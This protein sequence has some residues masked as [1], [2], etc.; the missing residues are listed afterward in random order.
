MKAFQTVL[1]HIEPEELTALARDLVRIPSV[2]R[3]QHGGN[4]EGVAL[5]VADKLRAMGLAVTVEYVAPGRPNVI[6]ILEGASPGKTL[7]FE[8]HTDV[9]TEGDPQ[10]WTHPPFEGVLEAGRLY[11]RGACDTQGNLAAAILALQAIKRSG[12]PF[13]GKILLGVPVDEEGMM[14]GI[15]HFIQRGWADE[16]DAAIICEP[17]ENQVCI[18]QKGALRVSVEVQGVMSHGAMP[19]SGFNPVPPLAKIV[20]A[21]RALERQEI[22]RL[23]QH[24]Y[25][26]FPSLTPTV[27]QAPAAG[28]AQLNVVPARCRLLL[29]V[30]TVPGQDHEA[31]KGQIEQAVAEVERDTQASLRGGEEH[32]LREALQPGLAEGLSFSAHVEVFEDRPWTQTPRDEA[33]VAAVDRAMRALGDDEPLYNGVPGATDGT[34]LFAKKGIPIVTT[35][36]GQRMVPHHKDEWVDLDELYKTSQ[37]Y[38]LSALEFLK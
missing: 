18:S 10:A 6:A 34:F 5:F 8:A 35:G 20:Q 24:P 23:G 36:A 19:L 15:K 22:E 26:G 14:S 9:V 31:L 28:E 16:V 1:H 17:E 37:I 38:A 25:L 3:P 32:A 11:G 21:L 33:I 4:E 27:V 12:H 7:M 2:Y 30:R 29:D 13:K